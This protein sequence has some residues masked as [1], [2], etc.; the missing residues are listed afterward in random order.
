MENGCATN[1]LARL[2]WYVE[3]ENFI[4]EWVTIFD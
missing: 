2:F 4:D 1:Q 3:L